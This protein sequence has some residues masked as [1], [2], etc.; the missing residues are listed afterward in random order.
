MKLSEQEIEK[1]ERQRQEEM[2]R[3]LEKVKKR[4]VVSP[5]RC[6]LCELS[7]TWCPCRKGRKRESKEKKKW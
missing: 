2:R 7:V 1:R 6:L 5:K 4:R 3:E